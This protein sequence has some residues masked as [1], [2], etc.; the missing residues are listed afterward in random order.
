M[1]AERALQA[2]E[3]PFQDLQARIQEPLSQWL[4]A[5]SKLAQLTAQLFAE[6]G[7][8]EKYVDAEIQIGRDAMKR[9]RPGQPITATSLRIMES[10]ARREILS[11]LATGK[12]SRG[13]DNSVAHHRHL[14]PASETEKS[15]NV[16]DTLYE[17]VDLTK[18]AKDS[19]RETSKII[20]STLSQTFNDNPLLILDLP[21]YL[22][23]SVDDSQNLITYLATDHLG[24]VSD[25][26]RRLTET[27]MVSP[28]NR[29]LFA[30]LDNAASTHYV[31]N[32]PDHVWEMVELGLSQEPA[33]IARVFT[34]PKADKAARAMV[35][36]PFIA[37]VAGRPL[38]HFIKE[39]YAL[40]L[41]SLRAGVLK[42]IH[43]IVN[44][45]KILITNPILEQ[46]KSSLTFGLRKRHRSAAEVQS[47][48]EKINGAQALNGQEA[49]SPA[50]KLIIGGEQITKDQIK[51]TLK[52]FLDT[53]K[54]NLFTPTDL[55]NYTLIIAKLSGIPKSAPDYSL[56]KMH[57]TYAFMDGSNVRVPLYILRRTN[58]D[59]PR[60]IVAISADSFVLVD[61][62]DRNDHSYNSKYLGKLTGMRIS[63]VSL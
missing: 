1:Q 7:P 59:A 20:E 6:D 63:T 38:P 23:S 2:P 25:A 27:E 13:M 50:K 4:E 42:T 41:A 54:V 22:L 47:E 57:A 48:P 3:N 36:S 5:S 32:K 51:E 19:Q 17:Y 10:R 46:D 11:V 28:S 24:V 37:K 43:E 18:P 30:Y 15:K 31:G 40:Y 14:S 35:L 61:A 60:L 62:F 34:E 56:K 29:L 21:D 12:L 44:P 52:E 55:D 39:R 49:A 58:K 9:I 53:K 26:L 8:Y 33:E 45:S 16:T